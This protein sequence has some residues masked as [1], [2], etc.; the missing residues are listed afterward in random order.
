M[1]LSTSA[2]LQP[3][4]D[5]RGEQQWRLSAQHQGEFQRGG[6]TPGQISALCQL[7]HSPWPEGSL[8]TPLAVGAC[9]AAPAPC[10][11]PIRESGVSF[12]SALSPSQRGFQPVI[13]ALFAAGSL[14]QWHL[15]DLQPSL[16]LRS[17][18]C[19]K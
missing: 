2:E 14:R 15:F 17:L 8:L 18:T 1:A 10:S 7:W 9:G 13:F 6:I 5:L 11:A 19:N 12:C 3:E 16:G 4:Q